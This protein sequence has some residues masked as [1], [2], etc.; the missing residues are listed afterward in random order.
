MLDEKKLIFVIS[1]IQGL[2]YVQLEKDHNSHIFTEAK[3]ISLNNKPAMYKFLFCD[4]NIM[5][6]IPFYDQIFV[7]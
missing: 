2:H 4:V 1:T 6:T 7:F 3:L 5:Q